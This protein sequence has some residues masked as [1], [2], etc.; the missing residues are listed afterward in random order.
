MPEKSKNQDNS[1]DEQRE[2]LVLAAV[3]HVP[4]TGWTHQTLADAAEDTGIDL[5]TAEILFPNVRVDL[6]LGLHKWADKA[7]QEN[8]PNYFSE[9][10]IREKIT[11]LVRARLEVLEDYKLA[12]QTSLSLFAMP[13]YSGL[14]LRALWQTMDIMWTLA[15]DTSEDYNW[16]T[17]RATLMGVYSSALLY[18]LEDK[19]EGHYDTW[20][21]LDS[22]IN[23]VMQFEKFKSKVRINPIGKALSRIPETLFK[24]I[25]KPN[26]TDDIITEISKR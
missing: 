14:G 15:G 13:L 10:R 22:R 18:F 9:M 3:K 25:G 7:F 11:Y 20:R 16:Y 17:K 12:V 24:N 2:K 5:K 23:N 21:F 26:L 4:F 19:S 8:L 6:A 1:F